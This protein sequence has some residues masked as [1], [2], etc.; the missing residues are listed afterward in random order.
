MAFMP[1]LRERTYHAGHAEALRVLESLG[2][3]TT[4]LS[5]GPI[6]ADT[7]PDS[8]VHVVAARDA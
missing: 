4:L 1:P 5:G 7:L 2:Y 6:S 8:I 3:R